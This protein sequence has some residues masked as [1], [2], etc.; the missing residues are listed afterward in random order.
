MGKFS[1]SCAFWTSAFCPVKKLGSTQPG[2][3]SAVPPRAAPKPGSAGPQ[4]GGPQGVQITPYSRDITLTHTPALEDGA[5]EDP[6][7]LWLWACRQLG[8]RPRN[9]KLP[10]VRPGRRGSGSCP[11]GHQGR[12]PPGLARTRAGGILL[13]GGVAGDLR[14][15]APGG[16]VQGGIPGQGGGPRTRCTHAARRLSAHM[17]SGSQMSPWRGRCLGLGLSI[18]RAL[19]GRWG[20]ASRAPLLL[21][22][23]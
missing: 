12:S 17:G 9:G 22:V 4:Q 23:L 11:P 13:Q 14:G 16:A 5:Q 6:G 3:E 20:P 19:D 10:Q 21:E 18:P 15:L 2:G 8:H 7:C 1:H